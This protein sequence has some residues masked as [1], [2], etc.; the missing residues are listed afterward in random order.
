MRSV[1]ANFSIVRTY[2]LAFF[3]RVYFIIAS[4]LDLSNC[5]NLYV[6]NQDKFVVVPGD[7]LVV[8][9]LFISFVLRPF[10]QKDFDNDSVP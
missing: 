10:H 9:C 6:E 3:S 7:C 1:V 8:R 2:R 5:L 4:F